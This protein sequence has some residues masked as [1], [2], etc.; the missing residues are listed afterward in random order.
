MPFYRGQLALAQKNYKAAAADLEKAI[1]LDPDNAHAH[2]YAGLA[3]N[4]L[5]RPDQMVKQFQVFLRMAPNAPEAA[6]VRSVL[7]A[8]R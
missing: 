5:K 7:R 1:E 3:Y 4:G 6:K 2:Y 8:V